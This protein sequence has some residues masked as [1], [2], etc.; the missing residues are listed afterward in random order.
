M[1]GD[2]FCLSPGNADHALVLVLFLFLL[3]L[4][5]VLVSLLR[6]KGRN[7]LKKIGLFQNL[8]HFNLT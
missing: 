8:L 1:L 6:T 2:H 7:S 3:V 5:L 4:V